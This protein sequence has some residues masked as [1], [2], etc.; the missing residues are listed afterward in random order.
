MS[1]KTAL[2]TG[3]AGA[4]GCQMVRTMSAGG[5][6]VI[7]LG[8]GAPP[9]GLPLTDWIK[10][11]IE[12]SNLETLATRQ[13]RPDCV[14]HLAGGSMVGPSVIAPAED[15]S[16]TVA[17]SVRL[18]EWIRQKVP[19]AA[20]VLASSAAVYGD[21]GSHPI[22]ETAPRVPLSPY[23]VH[24]MM[25]ELAAESWARNFGVRVAIIRLFSVYGP[26]M[27]KQLVWEICTRLAQGT[28]T[29]TLGGTGS[30]TRDWIHIEDAAAIV[31]DALRLAS[32][33]APILNGCTGIGTSV[34]D[35][36]HAVVAGFG[37]KADIGFSGQSRPGD[38]VHLVGCPELAS[39]RGLKAHI[40]ACEGL[41]ATAAAA[42]IL[43]GG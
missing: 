22:A 23:G 12:A 30:E 41:A 31:A 6:R 13:M 33:S 8:H 29:L 16:R 10:G 26:G 19:E 27:C 28:R 11:E 35:V 43:L 3:A 20:V 32:P 24:K 4:I 21:A 2:I 14:I 42:R 40:A 37:A 9:P 15:F 39:S 38:P 5:W 34:H 25:M 17:T 7:G 1:R 18:L 36:A